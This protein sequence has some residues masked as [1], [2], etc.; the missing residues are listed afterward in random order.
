MLL[1]R[2]KLVESFNIEMMEDV[3]YNMANNWTPAQ[4][5][6]ITERGCNLLVAAAAGAGKTAVLVE[7]II[8]KITD[9]ENPVDIDRLLVV[10]FTNAAATEMRERIGNALAE[11]LDKNPSSENLQRQMVLLDRATIMT[12]HSFCLEVVKSHFQSLDLDPVFRIADE[13]ESTLILLEA[14]DELFEEKYE[15]EDADSL[16][17]RLAD[18][19]GGG[20]GDDAL[21]EIVLRIHRFTR[22]HPWPGQWLA[23]QAEALNISDSA[24][25][26]STPWARVLLRSAAAELRG[27]RA[28]LGRAADLASCAQGLQPY[29]SVLESDMLAIDKL[30]EICMAVQEA[31]DAVA[32]SPAPPVEITAAG[33]AASGTATAAKSSCIPGWDALRDAFASYEPMRLPRCGKDADSAAQEE[34]KAARKHV[35]ERI[36]KLYESCFNATEAEIKEDFRKLYPLFRYLSELVCELDER[37]SQKKKDK[38]LLDFNDLEHYCLKVL[39][40]DGK[41]TS[42]AA[43]LREKFEEI[44]VDEYQDSNLIQ[45]LILKTISGN[46]EGRHNIFMVGDVKQSIYRFRQ[47]RPEL[48]LEKYMSYP[49]EKGSDCRVIQLYNNFRSRSEIING[50]NFIFRQIMSSEAGELDYNDEEALNPGAIFEDAGPGQI[51]GGPV[52]VHIIDVTSDESEIIPGNNADS[53]LSV[54]SDVPGGN[55]VGTSN[56]SVYTLKDNTDPGGDSEEEPI[57]NIQAEARIAGK[58][59]KSLVNGGPDRL[60]V[61]DK[62]LCKYRP[63]E[64]RDIVILLR[65][66]RNWSDVFTDELSAMGIPVYADTEVG[67][68]K[69]VEVETIL[70]LLQ[71]IDNPLQDI[72]LL[73]VLRSPIGG[74]DTDELADIR[75]ADRNASI[76]KALTSF[77]KYSETAQDMDAT[78]KKVND[79]LSKLDRWRE[80]AQYTPTDELIWLLLTETGYYSYAGAM[81]GGEER[82]ANLRLLFEKARMYEETSYKGLFNF[83]NFIEKMKSGGGDMGSAKLLGENDNV[84]RIMSIHKSKG[85][86]FPIVI[87][88]GCGKKFNMMDLNAG[89]LLHQELGY[90]PDIVDLEKRTVTAS[91]SKAAIRQKSRIETLSEEMRI[92][93]VAFTRAK[94]KLILTGCTREIEKACTRWCSAADSEDEKLPGYF[95]QQASCYL[96]W[97]GPALARHKDA[98]AI[99]QMA[100]N[101]NIC[102]KVMYDS[103]SWEVRFWGKGAAF[104]ENVAEVAKDNLSHWLQAGADQQ[105]EEIIKM[106][107]W[108]YQYK[109]MAHIPAK[110]TVTELKRKFEH[111]GQDIPGMES[112]MPFRLAAA[113][114][115]AF[116]E[117]EKGIG[118]ARRGTIMH[119]VMQHLDLQRLGVI[120]KEKD[121]CNR[122]LLMAE[123][124]AQLADMV[125]KDQLTA[126][127]AEVVD[128]EEICR[129]FRTTVGSSMLFAPFVRRETAFTIEIKCTEIY[130]DLP[131]DLYGDESL[132]LQGVIDCWFEVDGGLVLLDY[133]TDYVPPEGSGIIKERY[134]VQ[135]DYYTR[136]LEKITGKKVVEKYLYLF[137]SGEL[138]KY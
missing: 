75:L 8:R 2:K 1:N 45:E 89:I 13:T 117:P 83:I 94:E 52:E 124:E 41:P 61:Y 104:A 113:E 116:M 43:E 23:T 36:A 56:G 78:R 39:L 37:Y 87:V 84:V 27:L 48:F 22:S 58:R 70:S 15:K 57:D 62:K 63:A 33:T 55:S 28:I 21:R 47:A 128:I 120:M 51:T 82:Q 123:L 14:L 136:A 109:E 40:E 107:E 9:C 66:T 24:C 125:E 3:V 105:D 91:I 16:F 103:S 132:L 7:R 121:A 53:Q 68:F 72:P 64:Y 92:L 130:K 137:D 100:V 86:E 6:A 127:E 85:L 31:S 54:S 76:Y 118:A 38:C 25:L 34:V 81:P 49:R 71:I 67:Y 32:D 134:K 138:V 29:C 73:A 95:M 69:T 26:S 133:K 80:L 115:P 90:G 59:I 18:S 42:A 88:A 97:I 111:E 4:L 74:F 79:F 96:D 10:T 12:L 126:D 77:A 30:I 112:L 11:A 65:A 119:F 20:R 93:Y 122:G 5:E 129:F 106:L 110:I 19:Y 46:S 44:L 101:S 135:I 17:F 50:V 60:Y 99:R 108:K 98:G 102:N 131:E 35:K 114:K